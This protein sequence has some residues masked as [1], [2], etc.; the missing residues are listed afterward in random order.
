MLST[1]TPATQ[2]M[3]DLIAPFAV[4]PVDAMAEEQIERENI[5][6]C[7]KVAVCSLAQADYRS[8]CSVVS[9]IDFEFVYSHN[10]KRTFRRRMRVDH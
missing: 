2:A 6:F 1:L 10:T 5:T 7:S 3:T 4:F 8:T 9:Q